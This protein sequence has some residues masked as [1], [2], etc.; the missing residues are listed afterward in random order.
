MLK[1]TLYADQ[2]DKDE[3]FVTSLSVGDGR[4]KVDLRRYAI[5]DKLIQTEAFIVDLPLN[6]ISSSPNNFT[7]SPPAASYLSPSARRSLL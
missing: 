5:G 6:T 3:G 2:I 7:G 4:Y 1:M